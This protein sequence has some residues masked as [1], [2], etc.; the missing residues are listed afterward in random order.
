M[1]RKKK[2]YNELGNKW[3]YVC[4]DYHPVDQFRKDRNSIDGL[5]S[6]CYL[7]Y[8]VK[9][10]DPTEQFTPIGDYGRHLD[11][12]LLTNDELRVKISRAILLSRITRENNRDRSEDEIRE[13]WF[14]LLNTNLISKPDF[15]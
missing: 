8:R 13:S 10:N 3:C 12:T 1:G 9:R 5:D 7:R 11:N 15:R 14:K 2:K 4:G 6:K